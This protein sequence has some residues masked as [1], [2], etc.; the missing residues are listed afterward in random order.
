MSLNNQ[1]VISCNTQTQTDENTFKWTVKTQQQIDCFK[2]LKIN[3]NGHITDNPAR[4]E[5]FRGTF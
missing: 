5:F 4:L 3:S 2:E 1:T